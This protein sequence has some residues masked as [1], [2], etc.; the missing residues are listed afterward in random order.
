MYNTYYRRLYI[1]NINSGF[2]N[3]LLVYVSS[4]A[5]ENA[6]ISLPKLQTEVNNLKDAVKHNLNHSDYQKIHHI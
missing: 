6:S 3:I 5:R 2:K 1:H 4:I